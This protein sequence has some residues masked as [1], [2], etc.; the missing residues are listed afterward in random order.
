MQLRLLSMTFAICVLSI[1][2]VSSLAIA[3]PDPASMELAE[4]I[5][6]ATG[7]TGGLIVQIG[8]E[9][10]QLTAALASRPGVLVEVLEADPAKVEAVKATLIEEGVWG[11]AVVRQWDGDTLPYHSETVRL[12][13]ASEATGIPSSEFQRVLN[14]IGLGSTGFYNTS[15]SSALSSGDSASHTDQD[16]D[17][18]HYLYDAS[19]NAVTQD[20]AVGPPRSL[21]WVAD[22][23]WTRNHHKLNSISGVVTSGGR[24]FYIQ[25][26]GPAGSLEVPGRWFLYA[27]DASSGIFLWKRPI[28]E[29]ASQK[30][31]FR[32]GPVH[33][34]RSLV[35]DSVATNEGDLDCVFIKPG[36]DL[37]VE[38]LDAATGEPLHTLAGTEKVEEL[39]YRDGTLL[40][41]KGDPAKVLNPVVAERRGEK[42]YVPKTLLAYDAASGELI[43][44][45]KADQLGHVVSLT[46][47][48]DQEGRVFAQSPEVLTCLDIT[49]GDVNWAVENK[50]KPGANHS[51]ACLVTV[52]DVV[53]IGDGT[54]VKTF[55]A[56]TGES[57]WQTQHKYGFRSP[58][59][60]LIVDGLVWL[61]P[62]FIE[63]LDV[64]T[65]E[66]S[67]PNVP[68]TDVRTV[69]HHHRCYRNKA[70][71]NYILD[72]YRGIE[73]YDLEGEEYSRHNWTRGTCQYGIMPANGLI[74][75]PPTSC[76]CFNEAMMRGFLALAPTENDED[77]VYPTLSFEGRLVEGPAFTGMETP[78]ESSQFD[79]PTLRGTASRAGTSEVSL[80]TDLTPAW[81]VELGDQLSSPVSAAGCVFVSLLQ[82]GQVVALDAT[83]GN[84]LWR[85]TCGA[86][87]DSPPTYH[88]GRIYIGAHDGLIYCLD[89]ISGLL[90][91][92]FNAAPETKY[93]VAQDRVESVWPASGNLLVQNGTVYAVAGRSTYLDGGMFLWGLDPKSGDVLCHTN[94]R[95]DNAACSAGE[96]THAELPDTHLNWA[97][98]MTDG[99]THLDPDLSDA[100]SMTG[101]RL[102]VLTGDGES[103]YLRHVRFSAELELEPER[104]Q[105]LFS[106]ATLTDDYENHRSHWALGYGDFSRLPVAYS[107]IANKFA[108]NYNS[109]LSVPYGLMLSYDEEAVWGVRRLNGYTF[110][111]EP[112]TEKPDGKT[113]D[114]R[115]QKDPL[116]ADTWSWSTALDFRP[117]AI[118]KI[119]GAVLLAGM[120]GTGTTPDPTH[121]EIEAFEGRAAGVLE[122]RSEETGELIRRI[123]LPAA[124]RWDGLAVT[125]GCLLISCRDGKL[126]CLAEEE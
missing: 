1:L 31:G 97:Q 49:S 90:A 108:G 126:R 121:E 117:H 34:P 3:E 125:N 62:S 94:Y 77:I 11:L 119:D 67:Q 38:I 20:E 19:N 43:W 86:P 107:W 112:N 17:W 39:L 23:L 52:A 92:S 74:Y 120:P 59:D 26:E 81:D 45:T 30:H 9:D 60:I 44:E 46:P 75:T 88:E 28:S 93:M 105:H 122:I 109:R 54:N 100:F 80:S 48:A 4:K 47:A 76:G 68:Q 106:T 83:T 85:Y 71:P 84:E 40:L 101:T 115:E 10:A 53:V 7:T 70:T 78:I 61:G 33:L 66:A 2:F 63:G 89:A 95:I 12:F 69:G 42:D 50:C 41:L 110:F 37:P 103:V 24:I 73:F 29:W 99:K 5:L 111:A 123:D 91:W 13:I 114:F 82:P 79:W 113:V 96:S 87:L 102:D 118:T 58:T 56:M 116:A 16:P 15:T 14:P 6:G 22:P 51:T 21:R 8:A 25:D 35:A 57:L 72:G 32:N 18:T 36:Y 55:D 64:K 104:A 65:G 98:N 124:P 27:R